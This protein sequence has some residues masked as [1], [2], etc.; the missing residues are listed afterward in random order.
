MTEDLALKALPDN[1]A[2]AM[3]V[4]IEDALAEGRIAGSVVLVAQDGKIVYERAAGLADRE[5]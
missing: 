4:A 1:L 5:T 2:N 3:D